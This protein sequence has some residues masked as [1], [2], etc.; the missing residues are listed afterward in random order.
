MSRRYPPGYL[1]YFKAQVWNLANPSFWVSAI[2]VSV[3][4]IVIYQYW[5]HP[6]LSVTGRVKEENVNPAEESSLS[7]A[8]RS[9]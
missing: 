5:N 3:V 7:D 9:R 2:F 6:Y 1:L 4:G 8:D